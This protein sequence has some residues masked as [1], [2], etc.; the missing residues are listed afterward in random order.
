[1]VTVHEVDQGSEAWLKLRDKLYTGADAY[2]LLEHN[3]KI[4]IVDGQIMGYGVNTSSG[5]RGNFYT[6]R[7]HILEDQAIELYQRIK[8]I[9]VPRPGFI[10]N[11]LYPGCGYS[12]DGYPEILNLE[13][14]AFE[15]KKH[16]ALVHGDI[17]L[18]ILAQIY[19]GLVISDKKVAELI[20]YN[21]N[22]AKQ[23]ID[24]QP[25][26]I[27]DPKKAFAIIPIK[28]TYSIKK[29]FEQKLR[30]AFYDM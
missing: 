27:Y 15:P 13:V 22:F 24:G 18:K 17:P 2:K 1:M 8:G 23:E 26:P 20:P 21:P 16:L 29:N 25:N 12:P 10:T 11:S 4:K 30:D 14:K 5:F 3:S 28:L 7:G 19:F 6:K 9:E